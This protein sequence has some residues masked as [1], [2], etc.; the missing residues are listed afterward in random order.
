MPALR[1]AWQPNTLPPQQTDT[2]IT[3]ALPPSL[4]WHSAAA[5]RKD[6]RAAE[7]KRL[8]SHKTRPC[9]ESNHLALS[10]IYPNPSLGYKDLFEGFDRLLQQLCKALHKKTHYLEMKFLHSLVGESLRNTGIAED[11]CQWKALTL[12]HRA[13][14]YYCCCTTTHQL[15]NPSSPRTQT[16]AYKNGL[17]SPQCSHTNMHKYTNEVW[18]LHLSLTF[19]TYYLKWLKAKWL[20]HSL[21]YDSL[22]I[23][24]LISEHTDIQGYHTVYLK[25]C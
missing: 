8:T 24:V 16:N 2:H 1:S 25:G 22:I 19:H 23:H 11:C 9:S 18:W 6:S 17:S 5:G 20:I 21:N 7:A 15:K 4:A 13:S 14:W 10:M 3:R 12:E